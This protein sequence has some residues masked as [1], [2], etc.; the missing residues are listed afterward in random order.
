MAGLGYRVGERRYTLQ[1]M[2][3]QDASATLGWLGNHA[4]QQAALHAAG[5]PIGGR[6]PALVD[7]ARPPY[8]PHPAAAANIAGH[9]RLSL[10]PE[11]PPW[12][13]RGTDVPTMEDPDVQPGCLRPL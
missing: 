7:T 4:R 5:Q 3:D 8:C 10:T 1:A 12:Y 13:C 9:S 11:Y 6:T 2:L